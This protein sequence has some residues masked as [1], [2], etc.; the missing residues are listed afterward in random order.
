MASDDIEDATP[1]HAVE[2]TSHRIAPTP[3]TNEQ[4]RR[5]VVEISKTPSKSFLVGVGPLIAERSHHHDLSLGGFRSTDEPIS[6][7][8]RST[9]APS[10]YV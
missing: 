9:A 2:H 3:V 6:T 4:Y 7:S 8:E 10:I 5:F 1:V